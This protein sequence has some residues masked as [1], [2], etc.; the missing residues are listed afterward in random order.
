M[1]DDNRDYK[2]GYCKPPKHSQFKKGQSG[3]PK[4]RPKGQRNMATEIADELN[5]KVRVDDNGKVKKLRKRRVIIKTLANK[6]MKGDVRAALALAKLELASRNDDY[7]TDQ[8]EDL[9]PHEI[10]A[11]ERLKAQFEKAGG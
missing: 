3:N 4:G 2:V 7:Q 8:S 6:A 9:Q 10:E 5:E 11:I 1:Q